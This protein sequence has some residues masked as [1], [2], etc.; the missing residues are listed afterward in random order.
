MAYFN[1]EIDVQSHK[2]E[3]ILLVYEASS[4][5]YYIGTSRND[6]DTGRPYWRIKRVIKIGNEWNFQFPNGDQSF[7]YVW[8]DKF[9]YVYQ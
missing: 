2:I 8:Q 6:K 4:T 9:T 1:D 3:A 5:E 7:K